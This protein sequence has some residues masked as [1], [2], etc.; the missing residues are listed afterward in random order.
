[1]G[2]LTNQKRKQMTKQPKVVAEFAYQMGKHEEQQRII[3]LLETE[4]NCTGRS[5]CWCKSLIA[6]IKGENK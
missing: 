1:M 6:L 4:C 2:F 5:Y 3:K